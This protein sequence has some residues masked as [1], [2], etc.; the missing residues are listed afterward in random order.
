MLLHHICEVYIYIY[1]Y[2]YIYVLF[3]DDL[4][5]KFHSMKYAVQFNC[6][7]QKNFLLTFYLLNSQNYKIHL[8][9][10]MI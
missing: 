4:K 5:T 2:T 7:L 1:I 9:V 10:T 8:C 3:L 6:H